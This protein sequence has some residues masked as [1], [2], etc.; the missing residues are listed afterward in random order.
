ML[1]AHS[2][3]KLINE[4]DAMRFRGARRC[5]SLVS[6]RGNLHDGHG[7][8]IHAAR[9]VSDIV[10][11]AITPPETT[12]RRSQGNVVSAPEFHDI[13]FV[14]Q[15][16]VDVVYIPDETYLFPHGHAC[17][18]KLDY[19]HL[20]E[21]VDNPT[22]NLSVHLKLINTVQPDIMVWGEKNYLEFHW[23]R[24]LVRD[25]N[26]R[27]QMQCIPTVRHANGL[28]VSSDTSLLSHDEQAQA[29]ILYE[30][31][32]NIVHAIRTG[33]RN[34]ANLEK[35]ARIALKGAGFDSILCKVLDDRTLQDACHDTHQFRI[36]GNVT[37][38]GVP[39]TD[40]LGLS[41]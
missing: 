17:R 7:S 28:A 15:H 14:E 38:N 2:P 41:L 30:T 21:F 29:P 19:P 33:A 13:S 10:I 5:V 35:T 11:V 18:V 8:V 26:I 6:T 12:P 39:I 31:L 9:T 37:L 1:I 3:Q 25:L 24:E 36:V 32:N 4:L 40:N 34:F 22:H 16:D 20:C 23:L 27:T